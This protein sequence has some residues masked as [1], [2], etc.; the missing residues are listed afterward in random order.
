MPT[1]EPI[2]L[3]NGQSLDL[4]GVQVAP[5]SAIAEAGGVV[6]DVALAMQA[7]LD[8]P[9]EFPPL[10]Q[11]LAPGDRVCLA[12]GEGL[13]ELFG[14]V[15]GLLAALTQAGVEAHEVSIVCAAE[16][17]YTLITAANHELSG[18]AARFISMTRPTK[19]RSRLW[20]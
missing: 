10:A 6:R 3:P 13:P 20:V 17:D 12:L 8:A 7:A 15:N 9:L 14:V 5:L 18:G 2:A 16:A 19:T 11:S 1:A 4:S